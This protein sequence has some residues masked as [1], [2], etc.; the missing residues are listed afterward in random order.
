MRGQRTTHDVVATVNERALPANLDAERALLG[1]VLLHNSVFDSIAQALTEQMFFRDAHRRVFAAMGRLLGRHEAVDLVMLLNELKR[2]SEL[3][4]VGGA[5]YVSSFVDG[6]P[7]QSNV[8]Y[9]ADIVREQFM[10]RAL[11]DTGNRITSEAYAAELT[12][13]E[14][15]RN[16][17]R[18]LVDLQTLGDRRGLVKM[19]DRMHDLMKDLEALTENKGGLLGLDTG[20]KSINEQTLGWQMADLIIVAARP[21]IGKTAFI[22]NSAVVS[23]RA[24]KRVAIFSLEMRERQLQRRILSFLSGVPLTKIQSGY[25]TE[26]D[27]HHLTAALCILGDLSIC[28]NDRSVQKVADIHMAC[29]RQRHEQ[30]LDLVLIDYIQLMPGSLDRRG[31]TRNEELG[32]I[33]QRLKW[34]AGELDVPIMVVSQLKRLS[35]GRPTLEDL[36]DSGNLEQDADVVCFLHRKNHKESGVTQFIVEKQ[37]NGPTGTINLSLDRDIQLFTDIGEQTAEEA[38]AVETDEQKFVKTRAIIRARA[39]GR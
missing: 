10:L 13:T 21:S 1:A 30:G 6:M 26:S 37:R 4:E 33:S 14:I 8:L 34:L 15:V 29:R 12:T 36:R 16:A 3:E 11:I 18:A 20:F 39:Q 38:Q 7:R 9:Y 25:L 35:H 2:T 23:A 17:D 22:L 24:G 19:K 27:Y 28:I 31:A 5:A 32:D